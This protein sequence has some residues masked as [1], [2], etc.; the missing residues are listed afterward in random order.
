MCVLQMSKISLKWIL[1][2][3]EKLLLCA[4]S[5]YNARIEDQFFDAGVIMLIST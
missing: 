4:R 2:V 3:V 5:I 1:F